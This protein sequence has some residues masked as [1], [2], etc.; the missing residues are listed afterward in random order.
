MSPSM[1]NYR[2]FSHV[3]PKLIMLAMHHRSTMT[4]T[5]A[6]WFGEYYFTNP[7]PF[8][9]KFTV[10]KRASKQGSTNTRHMKTTWQQQGSNFLEVGHKD[11]GA[12]KHKCECVCVCVC[13]CVCERERER[14][15]ERDVCNLKHT[16]RVSTILL[17]SWPKW[18]RLHLN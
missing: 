11:M 10:F 5:I 12:W 2:F 6:S 14:E 1:N 3:F 13:V 18:F 16:H 9:L 8:L 15:R 4:Y 17:I 7:F